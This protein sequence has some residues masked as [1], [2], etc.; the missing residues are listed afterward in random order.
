MLRRPLILIFLVAMLASQ[1]PSQERPDK[2]WDISGK[3]RS[4][5]GAVVLIPKYEQWT[6]PG[7]FTLEVL[8][9]SGRR[10]SY[11]AKWR[12]GFRQGFTYQTNDGDK[13]YAVVAPDGKKISLANEGSSWKAEWNRVSDGPERAGLKAR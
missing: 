11:T 6:A 1:A 7:G 3:W 10:V 12:T 4:N 8:L 13:I 2:L 9:G 5:S